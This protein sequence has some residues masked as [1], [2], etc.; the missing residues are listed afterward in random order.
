MDAADVLILTE[1]NRWANERIFRRAV[2]LGPAELN[3][4]FGQTR[5]TISGCLLHLADAQWYWRVLCETG[6][7]PGQELRPD[8][9][10]SVHDLRAFAREEDEHL[11]RFAKS[12]TDAQVNR[13][14]TYGLP[15]AKPRTQVMWKLL[16]HVVN[17]GTQH[18]AEIGLRLGD[19]GR[20][21]GSLDFV[22]YSSRQRS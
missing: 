16:V 4:A 17:H 14:H 1:Y 2:H 9:F 3:A 8:D 11:I 22:V 18:R 10:A 12:L 15:R 5:R 20:S 6:Q 13:L 19:L 7:S 21:P